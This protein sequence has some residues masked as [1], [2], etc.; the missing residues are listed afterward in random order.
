MRI[1]RVLLLAIVCLTVFSVPTL[2]LIVVPGTQ[3]PM[4]VEV[5]PDRTAPYEIVTARGFGLG[6]SMVRNV[7][8]MDADGD[9]RVEI[10]EQT[11]R[12][13][14]FRVPGRIA[15]G[16]KRLALEVTGPPE[17]GPGSSYLLE[18][19]VYLDVEIQ[20]RDTPPK[21]PWLPTDVKKSALNQAG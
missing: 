15:P 9:H 16:R 5:T 13:V 1:D 14:R 20:L 7:Y 8:L 17:E 11:D 12:L 18:Q 4:V 6:R 3:A 10:L 19:D 2:A 21:Y